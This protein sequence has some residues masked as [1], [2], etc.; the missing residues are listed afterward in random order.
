MPTLSR[1]W[2]EHSRHIRITFC[3]FFF[4]PTQEGRLGSLPFYTSMLRS[5]PLFHSSFT[6][7]FSVKTCRP[8]DAFHHISALGRVPAVCGLLLQRGQCKLTASSH[9]LRWNG[10]ERGGSGHPGRRPSSA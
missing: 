5:F 7:V 4:V 10:F 2:A 1:V 3:S 6:V 8:A 9:N